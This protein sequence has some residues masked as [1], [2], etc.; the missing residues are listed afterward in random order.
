MEKIILS[1]FLSYLLLFVDIPSISFLF[2][3]VMT[4]M[5]QQVC[6]IM[7]QLIFPTIGYPISITLNR[8]PLFTSYVFTD[9]ARKKGTRLDISTAYHQQTDR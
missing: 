2:L 6:N 1:S 8:D 4:L 3:L 5:Q 9:W 7:D